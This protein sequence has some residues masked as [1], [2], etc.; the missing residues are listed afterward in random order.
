MQMHKMDTIKATARYTEELEDFHNKVY[1]YGFKT[2]HV[3]RRN[4]ELTS[5]KLSFSEHNYIETL[6]GWPTKPPET[7]DVCSFD[8]ITLS[9]VT[10]SISAQIRSDS[11]GEVEV[12]TRTFEHMEMWQVCSLMV[13]DAKLKCDMAMAT[14]A[15]RYKEAED[16]DRHRRIL[17]R[18]RQAEMKSQATTPPVKGKGKMAAFKERFS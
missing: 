6:D 9:K 11:V 17:E 8:R 14:A 3:F 2:E 15:T 13:A 5:I 18:E 7:C 16:A 4:G 12:P 10:N 1:P